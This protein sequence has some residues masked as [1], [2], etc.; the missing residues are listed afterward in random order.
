MDTS[1]CKKLRTSKRDKAK[2]RQATIEALFGS[3]PTSRPTQETPVEKD[4]A[5]EEDGTNCPKK[6]IRVRMIGD[7]L[8]LLDKL[9]SPVI[10][11]QMRTKFFEKFGR[12][13]RI[14]KEA[15]S[16]LLPH[17]AKKRVTKEEYKAIMRKI[18]PQLCRKYGDK[19]ANIIKRL[20]QIH[21][22]RCCAN[23][24]EFPTPPWAKTVRRDR[25]VPPP[26]VSLT[27]GVRT[28]VSARCSASRR[29]SVTISTTSSK[30]K[31]VR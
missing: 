21:V 20:V 25:P 27:P 29:S 4:R 13:E 22:Q 30:C 2:K 3:S 12:Q 31:S 5:R 9:P 15:E 24:G 7:Q 6:K 18:V 14:A 11:E 1:G 8:Q 26:P 10:E 23:K 28:T 17:Y 16:A 19:N